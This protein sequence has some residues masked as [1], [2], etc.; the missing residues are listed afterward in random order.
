MKKK[1]KYKKEY[2]VCLLGDV[3]TTLN[4]VWLNALLCHSVMISGAEKHYWHPEAFKSTL[5]HH[6][7]AYVLK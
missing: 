7:L 5:N 6:W 3:L 4:L 2:F 1:K